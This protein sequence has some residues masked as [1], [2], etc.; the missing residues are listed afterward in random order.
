[1]TIFQFK[2]GAHITGDAQAVGE[3]LSALEADGRLTPDGVLRDARND[4]SAL[5]PFFEWD[6]SKAAEKWRLEQAGH[7]IRSVT[8]TVDEQDEPRTIRAFVPISGADE[9]RSYVSTMK[10]LGDT[11]MRRQVLAQAHGE[12]GAVARKYRELKE[13]SEVVAA[14]ERVGDLLVE[15][16]AA[17]AG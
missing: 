12:L 6:D 11:E 3:R 13:L 15:S 10:A 2:Q 4:R 8:V 17:T 7:L 14:I 16:S 1:M 9:S 5:H